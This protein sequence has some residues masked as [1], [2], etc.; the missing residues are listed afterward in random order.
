MSIQ[1]PQH[2]IRREGKSGIQRRYLHDEVVDRLRALILSGE[3]EP[4]S[5]V[6]ENALAKRFG[7]SRT[8]LREAIK[9]LA[10]EGLLVLLP[11]RGAR[12]A[13]ITK[14]EIEEITEVIASLESLGVELACRN[15]TA[16]EIESLKMLNEQMVVAWKE[17]DD[18]RYFKMNRR[19]HEAI[20]RAS[21]NQQL[22]EVYFSLSG[23]IQSARY[24]ARKTESQ[25]KRAILEHELLLN[26]IES[27]L[28]AEASDIMRIHIRGK[29]LVIA[30]NYSDDGKADQTDIDQAETDNCKSH[31]AL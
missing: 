21:R 11:N 17:R 7:I 6:N 8:P 15:I 5:R 20:I 26:Y 10:A 9:I 24:T 2:E 19:I 23:R 1:S 27:G 29:K 13:S 12:V 16:D 31:E 4:K 25:W 14:Q 3:L 30:E 22:Q 18:E 28:S